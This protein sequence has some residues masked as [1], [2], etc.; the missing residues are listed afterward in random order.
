MLTYI[1]KFYVLP[2]LTTYRFESKEKDLEIDIG[3]FEDLDSY[4]YGILTR[5]KPLTADLKIV[6]GCDELYITA[7]K[8]L[9]LLDDF[10]VEE[11]L[12]DINFL[13]DLKK[14]LK[15]IISHLEKGDFDEYI[16]DH[17]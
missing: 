9:G 15:Q 5:G 4:K 2:Q 8:H 11:L 12:Q 16:K 6:D 10:Q 14:E 1:G 7:D 17:G 13:K 3:K